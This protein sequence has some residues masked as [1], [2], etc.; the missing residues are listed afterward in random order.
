MDISFQPPTVINKRDLF[1]WSADTNRLLRIG[2]RTHDPF[3]VG[4][5]FSRIADRLGEHFAEYY[6]L[7]MITH[8]MN[9]ENWSWELPDGSPSPL[10]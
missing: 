7:S 10:I 2:I 5:V 3:I 1:Q 8:L 6:I 4:T 9:T